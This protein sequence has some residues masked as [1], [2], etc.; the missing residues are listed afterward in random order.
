MTGVQ[1]CALPICLEPK[2][3]KQ[4]Y[5]ETFLNPKSVSNVNMMQRDAQKAR[6]V[7]GLFGNKQHL[8]VSETEPRLTNRMLRPHSYMG[9]ISKKQK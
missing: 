2:T 7:L 8:T 5:E 6:D 4:L 3:T 1:T 9:L